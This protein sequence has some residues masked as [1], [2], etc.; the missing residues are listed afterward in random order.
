MRSSGW[1]SNNIIGRQY[2]RDDVKFDNSPHAILIGNANYKPL[3]PIPNYDGSISKT[4]TPSNMKQMKRH[5]Q[6]LFY[7]RHFNKRDQEIK[8]ESHNHAYNEGYHSGRILGKNE[9]Q[10]EAYSSGYRKG[11]LDGYS[12]GYS[13]GYDSS[14]TIV[15]IERV[16]PQTF[17]NLSEC[18]ENTRSVLQALDK[19]HQESHKLKDIMANMKK[20]NGQKL[21]ESKENTSS[22]LQALDKCHQESNKL[23][24]II[25]NMKKRHSQKLDDDV[26]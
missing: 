3:H 23:K 9:G 18:K 21:D 20:T 22:V 25:A 15:E 12:N 13:K 26:R 8:R 11:Q 16:D 17:K 24:D 19:C 10:Q 2:G 4:F 6:Q 14:P 1:F 7:N 5:L